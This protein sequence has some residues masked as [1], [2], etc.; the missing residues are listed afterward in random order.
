M[1]ETASSS[2]SP[3][4]RRRRA[5]KSK[6]AADA[7]V[8]PAPAQ[9]KAAEA[10]RQHVPELSESFTN[11]RKSVFSMPSPD[12]V[13]ARLEESISLK[14]ALTPGVLMEATN[15]AEDNARLAHQ[16]YINAKADFDRFERECDPVIESMRDAANRELQQE[17]DN[18][19]RSKAITDAD[20]RGRASTMFPDEW[21]AISDRRVKAD[22]MLEHLKALAEL[23]KNRC[24]SLNGMLNAGKRS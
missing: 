12:D 8:Q 22:G 4:R 15:K 3:Q 9:E 16:L 18:K 7:L 5:T 14:E 20:V 1:T 13:Y 21:K 19:L 2:D 11:I 23:W 24:Y 10:Q 6:E 17:K